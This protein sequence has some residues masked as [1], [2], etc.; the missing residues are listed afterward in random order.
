MFVTIEDR[1]EK[2]YFNLFCYFQKWFVNI[3]F[4]FILEIVVK[5]IKKPWSDFLVKLN[6]KMS[7]RCIRIYTEKLFL[8][9]RI[10]VSVKDIGQMVMKQLWYIGAKQLRTYNF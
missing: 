6:K 8:K 9:R 7:D 5:I 10:L 2:S 3:V 4:F 1:L